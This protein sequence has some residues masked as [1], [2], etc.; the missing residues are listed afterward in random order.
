MGY[1][2]EIIIMLTLYC[3]MCFSDF[4]SD[5]QM[6]SNVGLVGILIVGSHLFG[7]VIFMVKDNATKLKRYCIKLHKMRAHKQKVLAK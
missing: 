3:I 6:R 7:H 4:V 1:F 2:N 5:V